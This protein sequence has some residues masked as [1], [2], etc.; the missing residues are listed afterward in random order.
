MKRR[1][2]HQMSILCSDPYIY[3]GKVETMQVMSPY[4]AHCDDWYA[5]VVQGEVLAKHHRA[6]L[7]MGSLHF[8]RDR[9][10]GPIEPTIE[11]KWRQ[12]GTGT[13]PIMAGTNTIGD[14]DDIEHRFDSWRGPLIVPTTGMGRGAAS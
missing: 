1:G 4:M 5:Q 11:P 2:K 3:W 9:K 8:L 7:I 10:I 13:Y 6:L 12:A 14:Y